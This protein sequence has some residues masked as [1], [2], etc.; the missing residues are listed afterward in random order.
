MDP[1]Q[2]IFYLVI[3]LIKKGKKWSVI[4]RFYQ[5]LNRIYYQEDPRL[6]PSYEFKGK[7]INF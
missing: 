4:R 5:S 3:F 1:T 6:N 7:K 2:T